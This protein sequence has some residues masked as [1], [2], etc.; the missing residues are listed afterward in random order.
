MKLRLV[1]LAFTVVKDAVTPAG[2]LDVV[3]VTLLTRPIGFLAVITIG[4]FQAF[5]PTRSVK[6]FAD[7]ERLKPDTVLAF[8]T[9]EVSKMAAN[10]ETNRAALN[11]RL[12]W[13][14]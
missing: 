3:R 9:V 1:V 2:R 6:L 7:G 14:T 10:I 13:Q 12:R 8:V 4:R 5:S 11:T